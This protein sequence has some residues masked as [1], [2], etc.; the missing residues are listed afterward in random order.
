MESVNIDRETLS[1]KVQSFLANGGEIKD[2]NKPARKRPKKARTTSKRPAGKRRPVLT[3]WAMIGIKQGTKL[4]CKLS[5][6]ITLVTC[7]DVTMESEVHIK[8]RKPRRFLG[9]MASEV[10]VREYLKKP[11]KSP[12]GWDIFVLPQKHKGKVETVHDKYSRVV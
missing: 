5:D 2:E 9:V 10:Y 4:T 12:Q 6:K 8:G 1:E 3:S 11:V 7:S